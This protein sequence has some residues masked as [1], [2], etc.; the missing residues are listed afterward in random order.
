MQAL[1]IGCGSNKLQARWCNVVGMDKYR[2]AGVDVIHDA[3]KPPYPF[4][5]GSFDYIN[6]THTIEH[7]REPDA[8]IAEAHR[9]LKKGGRLYIRC[10][11]YSSAAA[12]GNLPHLRALGYHSLDGFQRD[13][14]EFHC[15]FHIAQ[16]H[17]YFGM[18][19]TLCGIGVIANAFPDFYEEFLTGLFHAREIEY[20][21]VK[22]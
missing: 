1:D 6:C 21:L 8:M 3:D 17:I 14:L 18:V 22:R 13:E 7:L 11:H 19:W 20:L 12:W 15:R 10:P 16:R 9:L 2:A 4:R 5:A